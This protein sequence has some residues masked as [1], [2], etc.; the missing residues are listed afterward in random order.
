MWVRSRQA[1]D[2]PVALT[3]EAAMKTLPLV[4]LLTVASA[5][6]ASASTMNLAWDQC[7]P[8]GGLTSKSFACNA[9]TGAEEAVASFIPGTSFN[10]LAV[11]SYVYVQASSPSLP[12]W[13]RYGVGGCR[14]ASANA[15]ADFIASPNT[16]CSDPWMASASSG[17]LHTVPSPDLI[18]G[19]N[20][21]MMVG[22]AAL[23]TAVGV[24]AGHQYYVTR[25]RFN[26]SKTLGAGSCARCAT[27]VSLLLGK[28]EIIDET[29]NIAEVVTTPD[30]NGCIDWQGGSGL[31][32]ATPAR[33]RTWGAIKTLYR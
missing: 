20:T 1:R 6:A 13:W 21:G 31:C 2:Y 32:A 23:A 12:D 10:L 16:A 29:G 3:M 27:P 19:P 22:F 14:T 30:Q 5:F 28:M 11:Y 25:I 33:N 9:N 7:L 24:T 4:C 17:L 15:S 26:N 18:T 8:E